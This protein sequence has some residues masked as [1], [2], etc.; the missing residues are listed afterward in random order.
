MNEAFYVRVSLE[1]AEA[2]KPASK[3]GAEEEKRTPLDVVCV[4][5]TSGS[6]G[7]SKMQNLKQAVQFVLSVLDENDRLSLVTFNSEAELLLGLRRGTAENKRL[8]TEEILPQIRAS[9]G[10]DIYAGM[11]IGEKVLRDRS[12]RNPSAAMF[13]LTDGQDRGN[14]ERKLELARSLR[15]GESPTSLFVF[16]FGADHDSFH[17]QEIAD[18][19]EG[20]FIYVETSDA[21]ID[22]FGGA[23][24]SQ[25][26]EALRNIEL[27]FSATMAGG[28]VA[29]VQSGSYRHTVERRERE[30]DTAVVR[31]ADLFA[32]ERRDFVVALSLPVAREEDLHAL[33]S[34]AQAAFSLNS[35]DAEQRR[36]RHRTETAECVIARVADVSLP[37]YAAQRTRDVKVDVEVFRL[38]STTA[39]SS[40]MQLADRGEIE[41]AQAVIAEAKAALQSESVSFRQEDPLALS[42]L[43]DL[44]DCAS[45][46]RSRDEYMRRGGRATMGTHLDV[47]SKQRQVFRKEESSASVYQTS[48]SANYQSSAAKS[49]SKSFF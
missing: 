10:T 31:C 25:Q 26:S 34:T 45:R 1:Y 30:R 39:I 3:E 13:L 8:V 5:D 33:V 47:Y 43:R 40:A 37:Q 35:R 24:G 14:R 38:R 46:M 2:V 29:S 48:R 9:G 7:G 28:S 32:G 11:K 18:A 42:L 19:G 12:T 44:D 41:Q 17:M 21:V 6:M 22:A 49:K 23:I 16:G 27:T 36:V 20:S 4:L 15:A